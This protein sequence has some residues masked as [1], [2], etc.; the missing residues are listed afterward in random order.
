[1][2]TATVVNLTDEEPPYIRSQFNYDYHTYSPLG[3]TF[4]V[5][6]RKEF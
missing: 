6:F 4:K 5:G 3:R 2:L 1:V